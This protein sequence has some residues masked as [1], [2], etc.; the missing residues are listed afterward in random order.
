PLACTEAV[1]FKYPMSNTN[2]GYS[3]TTGVNSFMSIAVLADSTGTPTSRS[4]RLNTPGTLNADADSYDQNRLQLSDLINVSATTATTSAV[5][6]NTQSRNDAG[7]VVSYPTIDEKTVTSSTILGGCVIWS[8]LIPTGGA[9]GC[10]SSGATV[11]P[12]YQAD[13]LTG[14]PNCAASF[15]TGTTFARSLQRNV[16][17]PPPEPAAAVAVGAGGTSLRFST[18]E[19]Q[20]GASEVTQMTVNTSTEMLELMYSMPLSVDQHLC[21]HVD[22]AKCN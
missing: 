21:R 15:L 16:L 3:G 13:A 8:T 22:P 20:P 1:T 14:A 12:F 5:S 11:A 6:G 9:V 4:R 19:I 2:R 7:W 17:S 10:A 18:L